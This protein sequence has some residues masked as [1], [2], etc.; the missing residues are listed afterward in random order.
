MREVVPA[1]RE[2][3]RQ[4]STDDDTCVATTP[5]QGVEFRVQGGGCRVE[6]GIVAST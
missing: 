2:G 3:E 6:G 5:A 1:V 4:A